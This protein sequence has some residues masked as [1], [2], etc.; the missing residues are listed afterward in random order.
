MI[1]FFLKAKTQQ[2]RHDFKRPKRLKIYEDIHQV[3][4]FF[5]FNRI[6]QVISI[7]DALKKDG[8]IVHAYTFCKKNTPTP[9][10]P[11]EIHILTTKALNI[12]G[13]PS[14]EKLAGLQDDTLIDL[15]MMA[16]PV[17][18][19]LFFHSSADY[20]IG[21]HRDF[22]QLFDLLLEFDQVHDFSFFSNQLLFY[23][24]SIRTS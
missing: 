23:M 19:Y 6:N 5:D 22:P 24:K 10:V 17:T 21:F 15:T 8:K 14:T 9:G 16:S 1:N 18:D 2:L 3:L 11:K 20:R 7:V 13:I 12:I 4:L